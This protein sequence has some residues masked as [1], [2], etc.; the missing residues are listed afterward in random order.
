MGYAHLRSQ[1]TGLGPWRFRSA[2]GEVHS[3]MVGKETG[4]KYLLTVES[5]ALKYKD[6]GVAPDTEPPT[7]VANPSSLIV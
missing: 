2:R 4:T 3:Q 5:S 6:P 7:A 1:V